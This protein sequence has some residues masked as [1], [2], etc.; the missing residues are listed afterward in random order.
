MNDTT[1]WVEKY[2]PSNLDELIT[3]SENKL[4]FKE[5]LEQ[6]DI[7]NL[8]L[9]GPAGTGKSSLVKL[10]IKSLDCE[11]IIINASDDRGIDTI[12]GKISHFA[13]TKSFSKLKIVVLE[14]CEQMTPDAS[15]AFK[16]VLEDYYKNTR[17]ILT[18]NH[19]DRIYE[20]ILS[21]VQKYEFKANTIESVLE[22][23]TNILKYENIKFKDSD[24]LKIVQPNYPDMRSIIGTLQQCSI[25]NELL[26]GK[27]YTLQENYR[28]ILIK[29]LKTPIEENINKI[30]NLMY[31]LPSVDFTQLYKYLY[32][33]VDNFCAQPSYKLDIWLEI[34][35]YLY[36]SDKCVDGL[37]NFM[38]MIIKIMKINSS[39]KL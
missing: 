2:R 19:K 1:I 9:Y 17:F 28:A 38:A 10:L 22:R 39:G 31:A 27:A 13:E 12:R 15:K 30:R 21:R 35:E 32:D 20:P 37:I 4:K 14:E 25:N 26:L 5:Y 29:C 24:V 34:S 18:T 36:R 6:Q 11:Y 16:C 8:L 23:C 3:S 7:P 33:N